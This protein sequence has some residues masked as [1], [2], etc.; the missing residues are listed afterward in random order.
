MRKYPLDLS[1]TA[2]FISDG[3][4]GSIARA[5]VGP[6]VFGTIWHVTAV[7]TQTT[8][9]TTQFGSSQLLVYQDTE[10]PSRFLYG[11]FNAESDVASGD[12]TTLMTLSKLLF[13]W[14][15][16]NIGATAIAIVRGTVED[17]RN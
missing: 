6:S 8:S 4:G 9:D 2:T 15:K 16:G 13:V 11:S 14:T 17:A 1:I 5:Q 10:S 7:A 3:A 12:E